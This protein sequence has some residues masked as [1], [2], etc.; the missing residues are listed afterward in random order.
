[1]H[2]RVDL[3]RVADP[4]NDNLSAGGDSERFGPRDHYYPAF[5]SAP[6]Y[7]RHEIETP[8]EQRLAPSFHRSWT[9]RSN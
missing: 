1:M 9:S 8:A 4:E 6:G 5:G 3:V 7:G 2:H